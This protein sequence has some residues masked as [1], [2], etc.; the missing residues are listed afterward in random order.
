MKP[1]LVSA[2]ARIAV[3]L[4]LTAL[5]A[6]AASAAPAP[7]L[8][9]ADAALAALFPGECRANASSVYD[10]SEDFPDEG[11]PPKEGY[12]ISFPNGCGCPSLSAPWFFVSQ[13]CRLQPGGATCTGQCMWGQTLTTGRSIIH[14]TPCGTL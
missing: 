3:C 4:L 12:P 6:G 10:T 9:A 2:A 8:P 14:F 11:F 1:S 13:N 7:A 5:A